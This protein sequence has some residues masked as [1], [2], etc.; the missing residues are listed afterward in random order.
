MRRALSM[1][2]AAA[3]LGAWAWLGPAGA[4]AASGGAPT[5]K[6]RTR[7]CGAVDALPSAANLRRVRAATLCLIERERRS[8]DL[9]WLR[10]DGSLQR[11]ATSQ[12][13]EMVAGDYFGDDSLSGWTPLQRIAKSRYGAGAN[14]LRTAQNIG[15]GTDGLATPAGMVRGWMLSPPHRKIM[16][17][18]GYRD[19]G[20]GVA[21]AAPARLGQ[22][23][24]GA[25]YTVEFAARG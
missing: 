5:G 14:G 1:L 6:R 23:A 25:T 12:A 15:W 2:G 9:A 18:G 8:R 4:S 21:P 24:R 20:V 19:I 22:G 10:S 16:L 17:T 7:S 11:I 13:E 3:L